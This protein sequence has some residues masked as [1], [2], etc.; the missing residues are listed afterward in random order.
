MFQCIKLL[1]ASAK[2]H[3]VKKSRVTRQRNVTL[4]FFFPSCFPGTCGDEHGYRLTKYLLSNYETS[5]RP[6]G[7]SSEPIVVVFGLSIHH[8][9]DVDEKNQILT[10][11]CWL[12]QVWN[13]THLTWNASDFGGIDT[14]A[15]PYDKVWRPDI[16]LYNK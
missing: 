11:N 5:V 13:D 12:S 15:L 9:I 6:V 2:L 3:L 1:K 14:I 7:N 16:I 8:I 4:M 10:V